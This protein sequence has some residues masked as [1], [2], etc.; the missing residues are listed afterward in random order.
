MYSK[1]ADSPKMA[2]SAALARGTSHFKI[3][4]FSRLSGTTNL[5]SA[6]S[7]LFNQLTT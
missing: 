7:K 5:M 3:A 1:M 6:Y 4:T 2:N